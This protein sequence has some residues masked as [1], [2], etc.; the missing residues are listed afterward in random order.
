M[1]A[2]MRATYSL[3]YRVRLWSERIEYHSFDKCAPTLIE[4]LFY[5]SAEGLLLKVRSL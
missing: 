1:F 3:T 4:T 5:D 2:S